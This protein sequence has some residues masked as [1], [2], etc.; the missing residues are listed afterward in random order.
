ML[1]LQGKIQNIM[2]WFRLCGVMVS[3]S[4]FQPERQGSNP[5]RVIK[6]PLTPKAFGVYSKYKELK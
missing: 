4:G 2:A 6:I 3:T 1:I 5:C